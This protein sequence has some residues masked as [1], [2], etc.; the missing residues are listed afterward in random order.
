MSVSLRLNLFH[1]AAVAD[2]RDFAALVFGQY[3]ALVLLGLVAL[4]PE[5]SPAALGAPILA[6]GVLGL[7]WGIRVAVEYLQLNRTPGS[8]SGWSFALYGL[9]LLG[10]GALAVVGVVLLLRRD[11]AVLP[12]AAV[13]ELVTLLAASVGAWVLLSHAQSS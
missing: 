12:W 7:G 5:A 8:R 10:T 1:H 2:V 11:A 13:A 6:L 3:L 9:S 4:I